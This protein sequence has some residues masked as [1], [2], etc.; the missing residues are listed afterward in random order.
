[1]GKRN[2]SQK[3]GN[4]NRKKKQKMYIFRAGIDQLLFIDL[5]TEHALLTS[6]AGM[7]IFLALALQKQKCLN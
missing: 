7:D 5:L 3:W 1:M 2:R 6:L 4:G